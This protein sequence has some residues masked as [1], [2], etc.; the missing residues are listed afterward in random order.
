MLEK[1]GKDTDIMMTSAQNMARRY[2][3]DLHHANAVTQVCF[4]HF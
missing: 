1:R 2:L 3:V 4:A